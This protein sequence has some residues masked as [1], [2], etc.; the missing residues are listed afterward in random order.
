MN[1]L[2]IEPNPHIRSDNSTKQIMLTVI[3]ALV[4]AMLAS[5][6]IFGARAALLISICVGSCVL[7]E[8]LFR[9]MFKKSRTIGD[10]SAIVTGILLAFNL[11]V[12][13][14]LYMAVI[15][16]FVAIVIVKEM[17]GGLGQN[18]A[19]PAIVGRI[20]LMLSF[21]AQM[22]NYAVPFYYKDGFDAVTTATPLSAESPD[23]IPPMLDLFF[24]KHGG[25]LGE[26]CSFALILGFIILLV[27]RI[28][29]PATPLILVGTV[30]L[31]TFVF[32]GFNTDETLFA[33]ITGGLLLGA[34]FMATD[35]TTNP[36]TL[37]GKI[38]F[39]F[40]CGLIAL[41]IRQLA[42]MPEG[43]AFAILTMN[44]FTPVIDKITRPKPLGM[45]DS[46][47]VKEAEA[48]KKDGAGEVK[49][50]VKGEVKNNV[51]KE[52][53]NEQS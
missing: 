34:I 15:G 12:T 48:S 13:L 11:P 8:Y 9:K 40:G 26:T 38:I 4:P 2:I 47:T 51:K 16:S 7:F 23:Q 3:I 29:R 45:K 44:I 21:P 27:M 6:I 37:K 32:S 41:V 36:M 46:K 19:N 18:F 39:A 14:P 35:Y 22:S 52:K 49:N 50:D 24:G 42:G 31:G 25:S 43:V 33:I 10:F 5:V 28:I 53:N 30:A 1:K 20:V 17:F